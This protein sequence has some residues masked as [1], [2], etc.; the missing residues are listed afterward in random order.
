M[1]TFSVNTDDRLPSNSVLAD[2]GNVPLGEAVWLK[3]LLAATC[4]YNLADDSPATQ[5]QNRL[6]SVCFDDRSRDF[7]FQFTASIQSMTQLRLQITDKRTSE[8]VMSVCTQMPRRPVIVVCCY[9]VATK[10]APYHPHFLR[11]QD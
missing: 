2:F 4:S 1:A 7:G 11:R 3:H 6:T 10:I 5:T 9:T 8:G